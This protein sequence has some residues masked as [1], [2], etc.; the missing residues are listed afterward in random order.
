MYKFKNAISMSLTRS[1][2]KSNHAIEKRTDIGV[3]YIYLSASLPPDRSK[4]EILLI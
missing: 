3:Y 2:S 4:R 1:I